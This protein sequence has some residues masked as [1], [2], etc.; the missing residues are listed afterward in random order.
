MPDKALTVKDLKKLL[1]TMP[2]D[3]LVVLSKDEAG[4]EFSPMC[5]YSIGTYVLSDKPWQPGI[6]YEK[7]TSVPNNSPA[8]KAIALW[9]MD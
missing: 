6:L 1:A 4:N 5:S 7:G 8:K 9:P 3:A 2:D